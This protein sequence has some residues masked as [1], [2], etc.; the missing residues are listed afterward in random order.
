MSDLGYIVI[1]Y[2]QASRQPEIAPQ[3][4]YLFDDA[5]DAAKK[6]DELTEETRKT[7][8]RER[9]TVAMVYEEEGSE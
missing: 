8:R 6:A 7:G 3:A 1:E 2:N 5:S 9:Y 4:P